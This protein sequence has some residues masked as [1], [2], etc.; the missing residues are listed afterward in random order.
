MTPLSSSFNGG[1]S[2][3]CGDEEVEEHVRVFRDALEVDEV[4]WEAQVSQ[5][6]LWQLYVAA[7][8]DVAACS[9]LLCDYRDARNRCV[10][11]R[12]EVASSLIGR[13]GPKTVRTTELAAESLLKVKLV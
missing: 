4:V 10:G 11:S 5:L 12:D 8:E 9:Q 13:F 6:E 3:E 1:S 2:S 7:L